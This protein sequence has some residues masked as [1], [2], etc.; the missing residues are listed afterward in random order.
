MSTVDAKT[1]EILTEWDGAVCVD[2][3]FF[4][5]VESAVEHYYDD[6]PWAPYDADKPDANDNI[7]PDQFA[8]MLL[9]IPEFIECCDSEYPILA[10]HHVDNLIERIAEDN[11]VGDVGHDDQF[12]DNVGEAERLEL[13]TLIEKWIERA[14]FPLWKGN[15][16]FI[17]LRPLVKEHASQG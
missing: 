3:R 8:E 15:N 9:T 6:L 14:D 7:S 5:D 4:N 16:K 12:C 1:K 2:D 10:S 17:A 11:P 13:K